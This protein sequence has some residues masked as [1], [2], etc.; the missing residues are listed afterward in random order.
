MWGCGAAAQSVHPGHAEAEA[1]GRMPRTGTPTRGRAQALRPVSS[2][3]PRPQP[4]TGRGVENV[5]QHHDLVLARR[6][7]QPSE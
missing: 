6:A 7:A 4:R 3:E 2:L 5:R 1:D